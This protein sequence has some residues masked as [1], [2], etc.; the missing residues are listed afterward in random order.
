M[1]S[2]VVFRSFLTSFIKSVFH[3][4]FPFSVSF[5]CICSLSPVSAEECDTLFPRNGLEIESQGYDK[6]S[7]SSQEYVSWNGGDYYICTPDRIEVFCNGR[8]FIR[9]FQSFIDKNGEMWSI[10]FNDSENRSIRECGSLPGNLYYI[11]SIW[12]KSGK[13]DNTDIL[14]WTKYV[15]YIEYRK[16]QISF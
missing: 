8:R 7:E 10:K 15:N 4:T 2:N 6:V 11:K 12:A 5:L 14:I 1:L 13:I 9:L 16:R 3:K